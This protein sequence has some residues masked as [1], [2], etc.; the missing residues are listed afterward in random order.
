MHL[1]DNE[2]A[3]DELQD[4][5]QDQLQDREQ[6]PLKDRPPSASAPDGSAAVSNSSG[7]GYLAYAPTAAAGTQH[8]HLDALEAQ[9]I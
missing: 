8:D 3:R 7:A 2:S 6:N 4:Q 1:L 9:S 5:R